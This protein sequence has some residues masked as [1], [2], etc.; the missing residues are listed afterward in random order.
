MDD[1][2]GRHRE[3]GI[4]NE[5][6]DK[7]SA[8]L[9]VIRG[10]RRIGKSRLAEKFSESFPKSFTFMGLSP[11]EGITDE[12]ESTLQMHWRSKRA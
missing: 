6:L 8:S 4:L 2:Y 5:L 10:R 12:M 7:R 11:E 1:F 3:L 9:V